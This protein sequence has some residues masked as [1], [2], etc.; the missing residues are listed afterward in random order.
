MDALEQQPHRSVLLVGGTASGR[1]RCSALRWN[2]FKL[3][4]CPSRRP[5]PRSAASA[6]YVNDSKGGSESS[7]RDAEAKPVVWIL[8]GFSEALYAGQHSGAR[9]EML[10]AMLPHIERREMTVVGEIDPPSYEKLL[11]ERLRVAGAFEVVRVGRSTS[12]A[13]WPAAAQLLGSQ[14]PRPSTRR[15]NWRGVPPRLAPPGNPLLRLVQA[16]AADVEEE[17]RHEFETSDVLA[18]L[19][20]SSGLPPW[21]CWIERAAGAGDVRAFFEGRGRRSAGG[22]RCD[23]RADRDDQGGPERLR[24]TFRRLSVHRSNGDGEDRDRR[25]LAEFLFGSQRRLVR[26]DMTSTR[27]RTPSTAAPGR[28]SGLTG[29]SCL[30]RCARIR[31]RSSCSTSS[32]KAAAPIAG[33]LFLQVFDDGKPDRS[34]GPGRRTSS[35]ASSSS[36]RTSAQRSLTGP[37]WAS[38]PSTGGFAS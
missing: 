26:L 7:R 20:S 30:H 17:G 9:P 19:A 37:A 10:D 22:R 16:A 1:P 3:S 27:P 14:A 12:R 13:P 5:R 32:R 28:A 21:R 11:A 38:R 36:P 35:A 8:P 33:S 34:T 23:R 29:P 6:M 4:S 25:A 2:D 15:S 31:S 18:T 24:L